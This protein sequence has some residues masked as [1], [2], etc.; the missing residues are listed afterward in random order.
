[1]CRRFDVVPDTDC[2]LAKVI[3][4]GAA[5]SVWY[6]IVS[7][8]ILGTGRAGLGPPLNRPLSSSN[9]GAGC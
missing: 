8:V 7:F 6:V 2:L 5:K 9:L 4:Y 3:P 1:M